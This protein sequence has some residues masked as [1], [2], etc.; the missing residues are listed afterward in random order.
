MEKAA[1]ENKKHLHLV[2]EEKPESHPYFWVHPV[3]CPWCNKP[4]Y[5]VHVEKADLV[6]EE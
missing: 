1:T 3:N 6:R 5:L 4:V 2:R